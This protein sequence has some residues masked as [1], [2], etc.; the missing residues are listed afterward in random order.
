[1]GRF[2]GTTLTEY[3]FASKFLRW[4]NFVM[5][6]QEKGKERQPEGAL[7]PNEVHG[8][9]VG[10]H[11]HAINQF[12]SESL[13]LCLEPT[14]EGFAGWE[15]RRKGNTDAESERSASERKSKG[16]EGWGKGGGCGF[17]LDAP[18]LPA[19]AP[20]YS[21]RSVRQDR[22]SVGTT[23]GSV[24]A[25]WQTIIHGI[26]RYYSKDLNDHKGQL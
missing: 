2:S 11:P 19:L 13:A 17:S 18:A 1:M 16:L 22:P 21:N 23:F 5:Q 6:W 12:Y 20:V 24:R 26:E 7:N 14:G 9:I 15:L 8:L 10:C 3:I 4:W 25:P